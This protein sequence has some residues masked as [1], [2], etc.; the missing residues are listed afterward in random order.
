MNLKEALTIKPVSWNR[1]VPLL[2]VAAALGCLWLASL[3]LV[4]FQAKLWLVDGVHRPILF[5]ATVVVSVLLLV[6]FQGVALV[7]NKRLQI[8]NDSAQP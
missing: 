5:W 4:A 3:L 1:K 8:R 7:C 2:R 6:F